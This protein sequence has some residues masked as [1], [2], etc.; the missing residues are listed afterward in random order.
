MHE[1]IDFIYKM[2]LES[3]AS[4]GKQHQKGR[5]KTKKSKRN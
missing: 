5:R 3:A 1:S 4:K 2:N